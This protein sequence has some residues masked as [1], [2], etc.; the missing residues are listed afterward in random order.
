MVTKYTKNRLPLLMRMRC[1]VYS[2]RM[3]P[4][5]W[6]GTSWV[7]AALL[8]LSACSGSRGS[9]DDANPLPVPE[10]PINMAD[11]EDFDS[12]PYEDV[13]PAPAGPVEHDVPESLLEGKVS[14]QP[15]RRNGAGYRI[16]ISSSQ[17]KRTSDRQVEQA[18]A[19]W[20]ELVRAGDLDDIYIDDPSPP[21]VYQDFRQ[22]YYRVRVGNFASRA[23]AM[24]MLRMTER[25]FPRAFIVPDK[26]TF[27]R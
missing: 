6:G 7:I 13:P 24:E 9:G 5:S 14:S 8:F 16:Q 1:G 22:P 2:V 11:Y 15:A 3:G 21:P 23:E 25:R 10:D 20:R 4:R 19:W 18:V 26:V 12:S 27:N 17:D